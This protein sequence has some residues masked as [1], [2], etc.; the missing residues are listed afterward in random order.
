MKSESVVSRQSVLLVVLVLMITTTEH[1]TASS[2]RRYEQVR[3][4]AGKSTSYYAQLAS[5][6]SW[7]HL[8]ND[9]KHNPSYCGCCVGNET[10]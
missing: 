2:H 4:S 1:A 3:T 6:A 10:S 8:A 5:I 7:H 9:W